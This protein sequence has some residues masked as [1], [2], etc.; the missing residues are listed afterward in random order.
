MT[1]ASNV[2]AALFGTA[3]DR[4]VKIGRLFRYRGDGTFKF[5]HHV[6]RYRGHGAVEI[7]RRRPAMAARARGG[8]WSS[9]YNRPEV[10]PPA[11]CSNDN[12]SHAR[13]PSPVPIEAAEPSLHW[14]CC[15]AEPG[16]GYCAH[17]ELDA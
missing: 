7:G 1:A 2:A 3:A 14:K 6:F 8:R 11:A 13:S 9:S 4:T 15:G 16:F 5:G 10:L 12:P 17:S